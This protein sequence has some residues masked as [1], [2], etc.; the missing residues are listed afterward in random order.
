MG[1]SQMVV[2]NRLQLKG[3]Q[4]GVSML[5]TTLVLP[6]MLLLGFGIIHGGLVFQ[7]QSNLEYA[8]LMAARVGASTSIDIEAMEQEVAKRMSAS[9][10]ETDE[11]EPIVEISV[12]NPT[13]QMFNDCGRTPTYSPDDC[14][15][16][17]IGSSCEI[18]NFGL[19][20]ADPLGSRCAN[21][22]DA[23]L[24]RIKVRYLFD[25]KVPFM[26]FIT[27][28][29]WDDNF[30]GD[31]GYDDRDG[32]WVYA[33]ATVRMQSPARITGDNQSAFPVNVN[34]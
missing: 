6:I 3:R 18:P 2:L 23:N 19:Q 13:L 10:A 7:A 26:N 28:P 5:E 4:Q 16:S 32:R 17:P 29:T 1:E 9:R 27:F 25:S 11:L 15:T 22:G 12:L 14:A 33:V 20:F 30:H 24:L 8:A 21:I 34:N 31:T